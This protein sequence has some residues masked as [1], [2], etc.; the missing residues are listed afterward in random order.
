MHT[1]TSIRYFNDTPIRSRWDD[2]NKKWWY[3]ATDVIIALTETKNPRKYWNTFKSR[4][5]E[6]SSVC[7][8]LK[9]TAI[10]GKQYMSDVLDEEGITMV[11]VF[12]SSNL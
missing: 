3:S 9:L 5:I 8:Q 12:I 1:K 10:D 11:L 4:H 6:L 7:G 2:E